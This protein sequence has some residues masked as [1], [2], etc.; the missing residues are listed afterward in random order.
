MRLSSCCSA[1]LAVEHGSTL[2][3]A[4]TVSAGLHPTLILPS[5][6]PPACCDGPAG[7]FLAD[8]IVR[9]CPMTSQRADA[10]A[11]RALIL[12]AA[13]AVFGQHGVTAPLD[14]VVQAREGSPRSLP[15][16]PPLS[17][18]NIFDALGRKS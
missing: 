5:R 14:L 10:A 7:P 1:G 9:P 3:N 11:R 18:S 8:T 2:P 6:R 4:A 12:D 16:I 13:D 17:H 15:W